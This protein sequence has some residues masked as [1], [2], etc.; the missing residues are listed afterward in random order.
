MDIDKIEIKKKSRGRNYVI[1]TLTV[2]IPKTMVDDGLYTFTV[3]ASN[4]DYEAEDVIVTLQ[5][6][7]PPKNCKLSFYWNI[8]EYAL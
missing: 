5:V 7:S 4:K 2:E 1:T 3:T 6:D 8:F